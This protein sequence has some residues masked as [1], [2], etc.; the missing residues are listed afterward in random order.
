ME[1]LRQLWQTLFP[2]GASGMGY[3]DRSPAMRHK[4]SFPFEQETVDRATSARPRKN[5]DSSRDF[6]EGYTPHKTTK[7]PDVYKSYR[8]K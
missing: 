8:D 6:F 1:Y 4:R 7:N 2:L 5:I 3:L